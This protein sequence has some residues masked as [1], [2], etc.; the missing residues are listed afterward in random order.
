MSFQ[1]FRAGPQIAAADLHLNNHIAAKL[2]QLLWIAGMLAQRQPL[3]I[4]ADRAVQEPHA[5]VGQVKLEIAVGADRSNAEIHLGRLHPELG[6]VQDLGRQLGQQSIEAA[7]DVGKTGRFLGG[8]GQVGAADAC[9]KAGQKALLEEIDGSGPVLLAGDGEL[10]EVAA[11]LAG[12][13]DELAGERLRSRLAP[14]CRWPHGRRGF[15]PSK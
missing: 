13:K 10:V 3:A 4:G 5:Q 2:K 6:R 7:V 1:G 15:T 14:V 8:H 9:E 12:G 11:G